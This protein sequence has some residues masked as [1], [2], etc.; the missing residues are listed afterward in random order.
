MKAQTTAPR[1]RR[2]ASKTPAVD[3]SAAAVEQVA[4]AVAQMSAVE[5]EE[6]IRLTAYSLYEARGSVGDH[7]LEDW[8]QAEALIDQRLRLGEAMSTSSH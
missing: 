5:R 4:P 3:A 7:A 8:L 2:A 1:T 6:M